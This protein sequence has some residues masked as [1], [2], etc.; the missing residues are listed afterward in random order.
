MKETKKFPLFWAVYAGAILLCCILLVVAGVV[1]NSYLAA[2]EADQPVHFAENIFTTYFERGDFE[3]AM[4]I[5]SYKGNPWEGNEEAV[6]A[7]K[8]MQE[9][10][11]TSFYAVS[12]AE[13]EAKYNVVLVSPEDLTQNEGAG[14]IKD[15]TA[16]MKV[17]GIPSAKIATITF[18][19]GKEKGKFG[20]RG[21]DF[22]G[23]ELFPEAKFE[24]SVILPDSYVL[25]VNGKQ[26]TEEL[27]GETSD[28]EW[29]EFLPEGVKGITLSHYTVSDLMQAPHFTATDASGAP[30]TLTRDE[31][32]GVYTAALLFETEVDEALKTRILTGMK[33]YAK[34]IQADGSIG[35]VSPY[36][37]TRS[38]FYR[39]TALNPAAFV[40]DHNG[41][42]FENE[43]IE[44]FYFF[45]DNTLCCH[46]SFDQHLKKTGREDYVDA[47]DM[48]I[49]AKKISGRWRIYDRIVR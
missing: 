22:V 37:D 35:N 48:T 31:E 17:H 26:A 25:H 38:E 19:R 29:N 15:A 16:E 43:V 33:E 11:N 20:F 28:H 34:Y 36:F 30:V 8:A 7:L 42:Q 14:E 10:K 18:E 49:F 44:D 3:G 23:M 5:A 21:W 32:T 45:D 40:W 2:F 47:L 6:A 27:L 24:G 4:E 9:G 12:S 13:N 1:L 46:V 39:N 41:Y